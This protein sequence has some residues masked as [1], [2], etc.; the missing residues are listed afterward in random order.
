MRY[1]PRDDDRVLASAASDP[2]SGLKRR[3]DIL[4]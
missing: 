4:G 3:R 2:G 1:R